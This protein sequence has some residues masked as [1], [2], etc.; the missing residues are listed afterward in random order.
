LGFFG[1]A[2]VCE[3]ESRRNR[4]K[5]TENQQERERETKRERERERERERD[6]YLDSQ[7]QQQE[8]RNTHKHTH[9]KTQR[10]KDRETQIEGKRR[11]INGYRDIQYIQ[12]SSSSSRIQQISKGVMAFQEKIKADLGFV[13]VCLFSLSSDF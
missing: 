1:N 9:I 5:E 8:Y 4:E 3:R 2:L 10:Q 13:K 11:S 7:K 12:R 6:G